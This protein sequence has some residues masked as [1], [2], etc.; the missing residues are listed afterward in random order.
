MAGEDGFWEPVRS[1]VVDC[2]AQFFDYVLPR[3]S[4]SVVRLVAHCLYE[5]LAW[6]GADGAPRAPREVVRLEELDEQLELDRKSVR[7][8]LACAVEMH[9]LEPVAVPE[10]QGGG[11]GFRLKLDLSRFTLDE[12]EFRGF[13]PFP[14]HRIRVPLEFFTVVVANETLA[15]IKVVACIIRLTLGSVDN[16]GRTDVSPA[17]S[18]QQFVRRMNMGRRQAIQGVQAALARNYIRRMQ[19][20]SLETGQPSTYGL[21]WR[22]GG[23]A[24]AWPEASEAPQIAV[25]SLDQALGKR[26]QAAPGKR[27][28]GG[29][30]KG[31]GA[32]EKGITD[33]GK[34]DQGNGKKGSGALGDT[35]LIKDLDLDL[36]SSSSHAPTPFSAQSEPVPAAA[37]AECEG[38][39]AELLFEAVRRRFPLGNPSLI[40]RHLDARGPFVGEVLAALDELDP[41]FL[42]RFTRSAHPLWAVFHT[43]CMQGILPP[44]RPASPTVAAAEPRQ[45]REEARWD[46]LDPVQRREELLELYRK[47]RA[48]Y[49]GGQPPAEE[50]ALLERSLGEQIAA[51]ASREELDRWLFAEVARRRGRAIGMITPNG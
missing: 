43:C 34:G 20:G 13:Y 33:G 42:R 41:S 10:E 24:L 35:D 15:T 50:L 49:T 22:R 1:N 36:R 11:T 40:R 44:R 32:Q 38:Q 21:F 5:R 2:F 27:D 17:I 46:T 14:T 8:A 30:K 4:L 48:L 25:V 3:E 37:A 12:D 39:E 18:Q 7:A 23:Q 9:Y 26:D 16:L 29:G 6:C 19:Q 47:A 31:S 45:S 28:Q 51:G